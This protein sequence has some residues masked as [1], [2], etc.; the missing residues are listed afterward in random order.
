MD[1][2]ANV[3]VPETTEFATRNS[4]INRLKAL[5]IDVWLREPETVAAIEGFPEGRLRDD[6]VRS[7][8][9]I[10][11]LA[12]QQARGQVDAEK[13]RN[14]GERIIAELESKLSLYQTQIGSVLNDTLRNYFDPHNGRFT[15]RV[16]RLVKQDGDL[17]RVI[18]TQMD[19]SAIVLKHSLESQIGPGS[20][21]AQ[22]LA[23]DESNAL[24]SAIRRNVD[25]L[26]SAQRDKVLS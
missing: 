26:V 14:E 10:G 17:E 19:S 8:I 5:H 23:P 4:D 11:V 24:V 6:Y 18:R 12:L 7:S 20:S 3:T 25:G 21:F 22:L 15:E 9:K 16:E 1:M 2:A 13:V